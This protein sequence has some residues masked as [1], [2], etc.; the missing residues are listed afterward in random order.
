MSRADPARVIAAARGWLGTPYHDQASLKG[1]GADCLGLA[2]GV[3]REVI[4]PEPRAVPAYTRD[5]G[6]TRA[7]EVL[8]LGALE[9]LVPEPVASAGPGSVVLFRMVPRAIAKHVGILTDKG[10][11]VHA[12]FS[13]GVIEE[14]LTT[15]WKRRIAFS[16]Q[17]P[18]PGASDKES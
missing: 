1:V 10:T 16:F 8:A 2:R 4:G 11:F 15:A 9:W 17:F 3:W 12:Y 13:L 7:E 18:E 5:W 6:E 14:D